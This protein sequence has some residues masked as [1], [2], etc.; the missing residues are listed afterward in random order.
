MSLLKL[1]G[2]RGLEPR[3][4]RL[5][6]AY[7]A[8]NTCNRLVGCEGLEPSTR[9]LRGRYVAANTCGPLKNFGRPL[10][11]LLSRL[12]P[13]TFIHLSPHPDIVAVDAAPSLLGVAPR[14]EFL[15]S[16]VRRLGVLFYASEPYPCAYAP[17]N[18]HGSLS[19]VAGTSSMALVPD[20]Q[21]GA[22]PSP[23]RTSGLPNPYFETLFTAGALAPANITLTDTVGVGTAFA[24]SISESS[25]NAVFWTIGERES[26]GF[27]DIDID[28][29][30][31]LEH[32]VG[33]EPT[34]TVLQTGS[35]PLA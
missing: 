8:A 34:M 13:E 14:V 4:Q 12:A 23:P 15:A 24:F 7:V 19:K 3:T 31:N 27:V 6:G 1:V 17:R 29:P 11:R 25:D 21:A 9:S 28:S 2:R 5:K 10:A 35:L 20:R 32:C 26:D 18:F 30:T 16:N 33:I 22:L